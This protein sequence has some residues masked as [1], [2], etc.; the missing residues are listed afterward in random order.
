MEINTKYLKPGMVL[1][2][3]VKGKS[4]KP[5]VPQNTALTEIEIEFIQKFL[6]D[7]V[8]ILRTREEDTNNDKRDSIALKSDT[9]IIEL[10]DDKLDKDPFL[11]VFDEVV[12]QFISL[13]QAW[14]ANIPVNMYHVRQLCLPLF[15][16]VEEKSLTDVKSLLA[17]RDTNLFYYKC[18]A[19]SLLAI[20]LAQKL[21][22]EKKDWLQVGFA[23]ILIDIGLTKTKLIIDSDQGDIRH[24]ILSYEMI[25]DEPTL[26]KNAKIAIVQ[27]HERLDGSGF[28]MKLT[29]DKIHPYSRIIAVSDCYFTIFI[30]EGER[31][32]TKLLNEIEKY[33]EKIVRLLIEKN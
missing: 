19:V 9:S 18:V 12:L 20:K 6:V 32:N 7:K 1:I 22:Y 2:D 15:E 23:A 27:H 10:S 3:D 30:E 31:I 25:K 33:D 17:G 16:M 5:I 11:K 13:Y 26:T 24:P 28:P 21:D 4:G 14:Q 29:K 8:N